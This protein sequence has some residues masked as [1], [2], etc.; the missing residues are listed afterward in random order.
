MKKIK[1]CLYFALAVSYL[2]VMVFSIKK[3]YRENSFRS[4]K[5]IYKPRPKTEVSADPYVKYVTN[6]SVSDAEK[7]IKIK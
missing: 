2:F 1:I 3:I 7:L 6:Q 5:Q 4:F